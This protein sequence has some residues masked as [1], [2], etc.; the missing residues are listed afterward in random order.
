MFAEKMCAALGLEA[1]GFLMWKSRLWKEEEG[2]SSRSE[3]ACTPPFYEG[4]QLSSPD[5]V[6]FS[7]RAGEAKE[8][9]VQC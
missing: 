6:P 2:W 3:A 7:A 9:M 8:A 1:V 4:G 5:K